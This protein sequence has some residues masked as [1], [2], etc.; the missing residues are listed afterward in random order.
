VSATEDAAAAYEEVL[1]E[2][3]D[4]AT[5]QPTRHSIIE[6]RI[7]DPANGTKQTL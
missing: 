4:D 6:R 2:A 1:A 5:D 7:V 3:L